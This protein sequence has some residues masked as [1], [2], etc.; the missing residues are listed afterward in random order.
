MSLTQP[1]ADGFLKQFDICVREACGGWIVMAPDDQDEEGTFAYGC[2]VF[3]SDE[4]VLEFVKQR[5]AWFKRQRNKG[6]FDH[7]DDDYPADPEAKPGPPKISKP[8]ER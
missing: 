3:T 7:G 8:K 6:N 1:S 2:H 5:M 4:S